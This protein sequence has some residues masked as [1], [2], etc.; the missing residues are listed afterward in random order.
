MEQ[1][2]Q[3]TDTMT[4]EVPLLVTVVD[5][6]LDPV[7]TVIETVDEIVIEGGIVIEG[8]VA[9][10]AIVHAVEIV[11]EIAKTG[12][13]LVKKKNHPVVTTEKRVM[14]ERAMMTQKVEGMIPALTLALPVKP[15]WHL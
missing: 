11:P 7:V 13:K 15:R 14:E 10:N 4:Y 6:V 1:A 12:T 8:E 2:I 3:E 5:T 9:A